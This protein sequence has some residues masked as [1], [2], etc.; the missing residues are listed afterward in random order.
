MT[1]P[2]AR[3]RVV[4]RIYARAER[5]GRPAPTIRELAAELRVTTTAVVDHL[6]AL[7]RKE[8]LVQ[9]DGPVRARARKLTIAGWASLGAEAPGLVVQ[10]IQCEACK[11]MGVAISGK[12]LTTHKCAAAWKTLRA[13]VVDYG[14]MLAAINNRTAA[15]AGEAH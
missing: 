1:A 5:T 3:Q 6:R 9:G 15:S 11:R 4:L 13:E 8:L 12:R 10:I 2:S 14:R 7:D